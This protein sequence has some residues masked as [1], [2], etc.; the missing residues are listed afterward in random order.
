[1]YLFFR[2][3]I[4]HLT[5]YLTPEEPLEDEAEFSDDPADSSYME[6]EEESSEESS[7]EES[8]E[9]DSDEGRKS[10]PNSANTICTKLTNRHRLKCRL[11]YPIG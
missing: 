7:E 6:E 8:D 5:G 4:V 3:G 1:M 10:L 11:S 9:E 2:T